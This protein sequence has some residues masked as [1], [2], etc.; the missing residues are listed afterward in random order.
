MRSSHVVRLAYLAVFVALVVVGFSIRPPFWLGL[1]IAVGA[2]L[3]VIVA[4]YLVSSR[5]SRLGNSGE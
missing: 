3:P 4:D 5:P 2:T 1:A